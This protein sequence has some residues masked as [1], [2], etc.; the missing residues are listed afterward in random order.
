MVINM[1]VAGF[2]EVTCLPVLLDRLKIDPAIASGVFVTTVTGVVGTNF[3]PRSGIRYSALGMSDVGYGHWVDG[4]HWESCGPHSVRK[5]GSMRVQ[6]F[7]SGRSACKT[8]GTGRVIFRIP[9]RFHRWWRV[10]PG[11]VLPSEL[12]QTPDC[13]DYPISRTGDQ[14]ARNRLSFRACKELERPL[15]RFVFASSSAVNG[16]RSLYGPEAFDPG[17]PTNL[18]ICTAIGKWRGRAWLRLSSRKL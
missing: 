16:P 15:D 17:I 5:S 12:Y 14:F 4:L 6:S 9:S 1:V 2:P 10:Q 8:T 18:S 7:G 3:Q 11:R 13:R